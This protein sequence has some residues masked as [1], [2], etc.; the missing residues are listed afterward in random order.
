MPRQINQLLDP[1]LAAASTV[2]RRASGSEDGD[3]SADRSCWRAGVLNSLPNR[4][5]SLATI[6]VTP[7]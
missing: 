6:Y 1:N 5:T 2:R 3:R 4:N 7:H